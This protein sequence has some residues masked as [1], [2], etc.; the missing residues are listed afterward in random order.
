VSRVTQ[1]CGRPVISGNLRPLANLFLAFGRSVLTDTRAP[2]STDSLVD[3][4]CRACLEKKGENLMVLEVGE[5]TSLADVFV[6]CTGNSTRQV[7]AIADEVQLQLKH[8][9]FT[10]LGEEGAREA[11]WVLLDYGN[12]V[13]H[14]FERETRYFYNLERLWGDAPRRPVAVNV[15]D[16]AAGED[17]LQAGAEDRE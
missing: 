7:K 11:V 10:L 1:A 9:G 13:I 2:D 4:A 3:V 17:A 12:A 14:I 8:A 5:M 15:A 16:G 6:L